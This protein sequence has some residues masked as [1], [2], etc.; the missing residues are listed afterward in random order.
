MPTLLDFSFSHNPHS[1][2]DHLSVSG[3]ENVDA[4]ATSFIVY[5]RLSSFKELILSMITML[6]SIR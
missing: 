1:Y 5:A 2:Q 3:R 4:P 6:A